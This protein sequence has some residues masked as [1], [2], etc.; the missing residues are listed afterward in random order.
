MPFIHTSAFDPQGELVLWRVNETANWFIDQLSLAP[1]LWREYHQIAAPAIRLQWLASR[2][3]LQ[4]VAKSREMDVHKDIYGKPHLVN[5][6]RFIS[7]SHCQGYAAAIAANHAVG[8]DVERVNPRVQR[9]KNRFLTEQ[10]QAIVGDSDAD[11]MLAWSVKETVYKMYGNKKLIFKEHILLLERNNET[12]EVL[13][14][15]VTPDEQQR[16]QVGFCFLEE[17]VLSWV[18]QPA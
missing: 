9:I 14:N 1:N 6:S 13:V 2:F 8:V 15:L 3:A 18:Q 12:R 4:Q 16:L 11:L 7:I 10:E 17:V 5:D